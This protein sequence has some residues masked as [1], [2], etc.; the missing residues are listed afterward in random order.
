MGR[1]QFGPL[2]MD[3]ASRAGELLDYMAPDSDN[4][5]GPLEWI[6]GDAVALE[7][8]LE[9]EETVPL[10][11]VPYEVEGEDRRKLHD[12]LHAFH[13]AL[14]FDE[15]ERGWLG[16]T[17]NNI[18]KIARTTEEIPRVI[19]GH[20]DQIMIAGVRRVVSGR[21]LM[22]RWIAWHREAGEYEGQGAID[23]ARDALRTMQELVPF[24]A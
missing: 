8:W 17:Y 3:I 10:L 19:E 11:E 22:R 9:I 16:R 1:Q 15:A 21:D 18:D 24:S 23:Q 4:A 5:G 6:K 20:E 2:G 13:T 14:P 7:D 12:T